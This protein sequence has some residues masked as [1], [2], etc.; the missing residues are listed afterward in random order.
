[1]YTFEVNTVKSTEKA[2]AA[3]VVQKEAVMDS[4]TSITPLS[5]TETPQGLQGSISNDYIWPF[6]EGVGRVS[7]GLHADNAYDFAAPKGTPLYAIHDGTVLISH[8]TGYNGGYGLYVVIDFTD[9]RQAIIG[10]MSKVVSRAGDVVKQGDIVG[11]VGSTGKSTGPHT[12]IGF[13]GTLSNPYNGLKV[14]STDIQNND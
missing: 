8:P 10:H 11:Y 12:H 2:E 14:N 3:P 13:H 4:D 9:G 5:S 6:P 7:Q 1:L